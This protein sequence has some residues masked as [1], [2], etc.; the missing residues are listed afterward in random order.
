M[1]R[2]SRPI[3]KR[4]TRYT[5]PKRRHDSATGP[6]IAR[7]LDSRHNY[8]HYLPRVAN[9]FPPNEK[10]AAVGQTAFSAIARPTGPPKLH[11][12][13]GASRR[14]LPRPD[15]GTGKSR[16]S[17]QRQEAGHSG[18]NGSTARESLQRE[19]SSRQTGFALKRVPRTNLTSCN[20]QSKRFD[21]AAAAAA[22]DA[23]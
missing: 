6:E 3:A 4:G 2:S 18:L 23:D 20:N 19:L 21:R 10:L 1:L 11:A 8:R 17:R 16:Y 9:L 15:K 5:C 22:I 14:V 12:L 13:R 7:R